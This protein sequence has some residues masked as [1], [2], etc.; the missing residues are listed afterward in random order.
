VE[1]TSRN[2]KR[3]TTSKAAGSGA[4]APSTMPV[5]GGTATSVDGSPRPPDKPV[6][7]EPGVIPRPQPTPQPPPTPPPGAPSQEG[8]V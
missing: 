7:A 3:G 6:G 1:F 8:A 2:K 4:A 5:A